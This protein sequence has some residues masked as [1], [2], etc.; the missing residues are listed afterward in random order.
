VSFAVHKSHVMASGEAVWSEPAATAARSALATAA[1]A[2]PNKD[3][4]AAGSGAFR[5]C[6][7]AALPLRFRRYRNAST[8]ATGPNSSAGIS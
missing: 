2:F 5:R 1:G 3:Q 6:V 7:P 8:W 4:E